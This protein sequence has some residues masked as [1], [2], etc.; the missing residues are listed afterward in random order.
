MQCSTVTGPPPVTVTV[1]IPGLEEFAK[2]AHHLVPL[3]S[4]ITP[5]PIM[6]TLI[7]NALV[8]WI[9]R[10]GKPK[11]LFL[12]VLTQL[13]FF[14]LQVEMIIFCWLNSS[15]YFWQFTVDKDVI[16]PKMGQGTQEW[17]K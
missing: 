12:F 16:L 6:I 1:Q 7:N 13:N 2:A 3:S 11:G 4:E 17:T 14:L 9:K 15:H 10:K 8:P 5:E